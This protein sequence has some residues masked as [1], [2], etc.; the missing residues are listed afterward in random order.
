MFWNPGAGSW[1]VAGDA[2]FTPRLSSHNWVTTFSTSAQHGVGKNEPCALELP[3]FSTSNCNRFET[4]NT[5]QSTTLHFLA[6]QRRAR[7][8]SWTEFNRLPE[9]WMKVINQAAIY[10][11]VYKN[12]FDCATVLCTWYSNT[13]MAKYKTIEINHI[14]KI[15]SSRWLRW[16]R[17]INPNPWVL[18]PVSN[19]QWS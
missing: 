13:K 10:V 19:N 14:M 3:I 6:L 1:Q 8:T 18:V 16:K 12:S 17:K 15:A 9:R 7:H 2:F 4:M 11:Y 5:N